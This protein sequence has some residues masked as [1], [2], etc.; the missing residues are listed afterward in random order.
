MT[1]RCPGPG[2]KAPTVSGA[3]SSSSA[4]AAPGSLHFPLKTSCLEGR[5]LQ[6]GGRRTQA[7]ERVETTGGHRPGF[8]AQLGPACPEAE[9]ASGSGWASS[10]PVVCQGCMLGR[11]PAPLLWQTPCNLTARPGTGGLAMHT[12][13]DSGNYGNS[14]VPA[15]GADPPGPRGCDPASPQPVQLSWPCSHGSVLCSGCLAQ[16][17]QHAVGGELEGRP[18][19][20]T[21]SRAAGPRAG[22]GDSRPAGFSGLTLSAPLGLQR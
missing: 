15:G 5:S 14:F 8:S 13:Q 9:G 11:Q 16:G 10:Q 19:E 21:V 3:S 20:S 17:V 18:L 12:W 1:G 7:N 22:A 6:R 4:A 2:C